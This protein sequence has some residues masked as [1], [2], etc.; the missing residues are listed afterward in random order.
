MKLRAAVL[1]ATRDFFN[2]NGYT[3]ADVPILTPAVIPEA[4][5][6]LFKTEQITPY[7]NSRDLFL[8]PSPE[9]Y[10]KRLIAGGSGN[11]FN[12]SHSFRNS[13]QSGR[14]HNPEFSML[15]WYTM[16]AHYMDSIHTAEALVSHM[17][18]LPGISADKA[19]ALEPPFTRMSMT[20]VF[21]SFTGIDIS[22]HCTGELSD[23]EQRSGLRKYAARQGLGVS[24]GDSWEELFNLLFVHCIEPKLPTDRPLVIYNYPAGIPALAKPADEPGRLER[25]ELYAGGIE[26]ANCYSEETCHKRVSKFFMDEAEE[27][28][29]ALVPVKPDFDWCEMYRN[30]FPEC[31]GTALGMDRLMMLL[32]GSKSLEGV[33]LFPLSDIIRDH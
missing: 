12:I 5:I 22:K 28:K 32:S 17:L 21:D 4:S 27:K 1:A 33:I 19:A 29:G 14:W 11:I 15:E 2:S 13:E 18:G 26:L 20:E 16:G 6:E 9:Y 23:D 31:S 3:E 25:W 7:G 30:G 8:L 10:L 24:E